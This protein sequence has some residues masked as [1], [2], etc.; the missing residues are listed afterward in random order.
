[1][2]QKRIAD[3]IRSGIKPAEKI[4]LELEHFIITADNKS[5]GYY[6]ADGVEAVLLELSPNFERKIYSEGKL[7]ALSNGKYHL[8]LEPAAQL[9]ISIEP[10]ESVRETEEYYR[11]FLRLVEPAL[12]KR[13]YRMETYGYQPYDKAEE[14]ELIPKERY[15]FMDR[16]LRTVGHF[17][18]NMM[19]GTASAQVSI[20]YTSEEDCL[21]KFRLANVLAPLFAMITDNSPIFEGEPYP[22]RMVR[23]RIWQDVDPARC[24][25]VPGCLEHGFTIDSYAAYLLDAP[26]ILIEEAEGTVYT[27][28]KTVREIYKDREMTTEE[29]EHILSMFFPDVRLK[30]YIEIRPAD[31]MPIEYTLSYAAFVRGIFLDLER[32]EKITGIA[33]ITEKDVVSSRAELIKCGFDA[34]VY[35]RSVREILAELLETAKESLTMD[36]REYLPKMEEIIMSEKPLKDRY[37]EGR[38]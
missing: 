32:A 25:I 12:K 13:G 6:G 3:Y 34:V 36:E 29:I 16:Y 35:G 18:V 14:L 15:R 31:S 33:G 37:T 17:G 27:G 7:I 10:C 30:Q 2:N 21:R 19:R 23:S 26:A 9:E 11:D 8:T 28:K 5:A 22:G 20:D 1:M 38:G 24:G 4:G